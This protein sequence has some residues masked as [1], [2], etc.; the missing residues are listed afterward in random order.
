MLPNVD[1]DGLAFFNGLAGHLEL[2]ERGD[3]LQVGARFLRFDG[4]QFQKLTEAELD[5]V[6]LLEPQVRLVGEGRA[7]CDFDAPNGESFRV[8]D[9]IDAIERTERRVRNDPDWAGGA[10]RENILF[11]GIHYDTDGLWRIVWGA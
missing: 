4:Q 3:E 2:V 7:A 1:S 5:R 11:E 6:V 10:D 9:L 8:R